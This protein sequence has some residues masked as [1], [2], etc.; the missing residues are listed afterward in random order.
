M[1]TNLQQTLP[2]MGKYLPISKEY[3][4]TCNKHV[5]T[6]QIRANLQY[7]SLLSQICTYLLQKYI[8][9]NFLHMACHMGGWIKGQK[10]DLFFIKHS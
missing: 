9:V 5:C 8:H 2:N 4:C 7:M 6:Y 1:N 10:C 3:L